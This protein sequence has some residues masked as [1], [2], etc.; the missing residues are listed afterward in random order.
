MP[1]LIHVCRMLAMTFI[2]FVLGLADARANERAAMVFL[3]TGEKYATQEQAG[4]AVE[5][6]ANYVSQQMTGSTNA[7]LARVFNSPAKTIE[8]ITAKKPPVGIVSPGF[9]L[10]YHKTLGMEPL[11]ETQRTGVSS[12]RYVLVARTTGVPPPGEWAGKMVATQLAAESRYVLGVILQDNF[13]GEIRFK[14]IDDVEVAIIELAENKPGAPDAVLIEEV[15]WKELFAGDDEI[16]PKLQ[17]IYRSPELPGELV[18]A[19]KPNVGGFSLDAFKDALRG[20]PGT[21]TGR[22]I[23]RNIRLESFNHTNQERLQ[24]AEKL[25]NPK[26]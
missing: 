18:V 23:L 12:E 25:F 24:H 2:A 19:F 26:P 6:L 8:F 20:M 11:L 21:E 17:V 15:T 5:S 14:E 4:G 3:K 22:H 10:T 1:T 9:Y 16:G 7:F 13:G